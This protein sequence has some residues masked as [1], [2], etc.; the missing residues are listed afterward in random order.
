MSCVNKLLFLKFTKSSRIQDKS[1]A[2]LFPFSIFSMRIFG[3]FSKNNFSF[4][5]TI[6]ILAQSFS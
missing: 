4:A 5:G 3:S 2:M 6:H 1:L